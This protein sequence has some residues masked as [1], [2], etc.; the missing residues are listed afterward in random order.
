VFSFC[1][2]TERG[3]TKEGIVANFKPCLREYWP[4]GEYCGKNVRDFWQG[5][6]DLKAKIGREK[7]GE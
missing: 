3:V 2:T 7:C 1:I 6:K 4:D 5:L